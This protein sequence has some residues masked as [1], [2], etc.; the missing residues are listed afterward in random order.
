MTRPFALFLLGTSLTLSSSG[1]F[2]SYVDPFVGTAGTGHTFPAACV[3][4]GLVQAGPDTGFGD[5]PHCS[6]YIYTDK[7]ICGF[8]QTHLNGTGCPDLG[9]LRLLPLPGGKTC[10]MAAKNLS[11]ENK[12]VKAVSLNGNPITDW[13]IRH[14]DIMTGGELV[15]EMTAK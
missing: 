7:T 13:K 8:T 14:A 15:F 9:D 5:W 12:Y 3:P 1:D 2:A 4:F 10:T 6:G 11:K